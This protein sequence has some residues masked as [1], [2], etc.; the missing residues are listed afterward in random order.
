MWLVDVVNGLS[1]PRGQMTIWACVHVVGWLRWS[2]F[3]CG[4]SYPFG[5]LVALVTASAKAHECP[6]IRSKSAKFS[7]FS[8]T[9]VWS[10][11]VLWLLDSWRPLQRVW[12]QAIEM[13]FFSRALRLRARKWIDQVP[14]G[15]TM[16]PHGWATMR[17]L[18][19]FLT[20]FEFQRTTDL[21]KP[22]NFFEKSN[23]LENWRG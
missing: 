22:R 10:G 5:Q 17:P 18:L 19:V 2:M 4:R 9:W 8:F 15:A 20:F 1:R 23:S 3:F 16:R 14:R 21:S 12:G 13:T 7:F 6:S 11:F